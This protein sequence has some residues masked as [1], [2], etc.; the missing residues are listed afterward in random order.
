MMENSPSYHFD[1]LFQK[2]GNSPIYIAPSQYEVID[3]T[4]SDI[5]VFGVLLLSGLWPSHL[6]LFYADVDKLT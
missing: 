3:P 6:I 1:C 5:L 4:L 2:V